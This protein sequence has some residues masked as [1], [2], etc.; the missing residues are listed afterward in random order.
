[1]AFDEYG[2]NDEREPALPIHELVIKGNVPE[3]Q[4]APR[5]EGNR[6]IFGDGTQL[7]FTE[8]GGRLFTAN[9]D[10]VNQPLRMTE[11][12]SSPSVSSEAFEMIKIQLREQLEGDLD[13]DM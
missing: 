2:N 8:S 7:E 4:E 11:G 9:G 3:G 12:L 6:V 10:V 1:M 13:L 5:L